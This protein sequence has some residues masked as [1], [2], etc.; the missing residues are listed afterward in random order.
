MNKQI[1]S[2]KHEIEFI[3]RDEKERKTIHTVEYRHPQANATDSN[4]NMQKKTSINYVQEKKNCI[5]TE[6]ID[7]DMN[8]F[9]SL[10]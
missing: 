8:H 1:F 3:T 4:R 2:N 10:V 6:I 7:A 5:V 9:I